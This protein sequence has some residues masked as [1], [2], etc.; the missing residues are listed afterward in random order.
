MIW[1][2]F[3]LVCTDKNFYKNFY[4]QVMF[5]KEKKEKGEKEE[6]QHR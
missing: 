5:S 1:C 2:L 3:K 6:K 4:N